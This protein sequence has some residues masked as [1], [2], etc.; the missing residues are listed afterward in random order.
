M[1]KI[2]T[3]VLEHH[4]VRRTGPGATA[5]P[6]KPAASEGK[7]GKGEAGAAPAPEGKPNGSSPGGARRPPNGARP[8]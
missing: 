7:S 8:S 6:A 3:K 4:G 1:E 5:E 2:E